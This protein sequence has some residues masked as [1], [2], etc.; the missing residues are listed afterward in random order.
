MSKLTFDICRDWK[1]ILDAFPSSRR[2][3]ETGIDCYALDDYPGCVFH[4][5]R[6]AE[7]GLRAIAR[8]RGITS[9]GRKKPKPIEWGTWQEVFD[10]I[11]TELAVIRQ[12]SL[13]PQRDAA[14]SFYDTALSDLRT[15]RGLYRDPTM[16]FRERYDKGEAYSAMFRAKSLMA[17]ISTKLV[18]ISPRKI[19]WK[20]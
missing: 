16:H 20:L 14:L 9:L 12:A 8:E 17:M 15:M 11:G 19:N 10:A 7:L 18:E 5:M 3:I 1:G 2:E 4:M 6:V 13:G